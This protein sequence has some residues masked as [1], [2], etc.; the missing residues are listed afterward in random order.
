MQKKEEKTATFR[1]VSISLSLSHS[2][3]LTS[4][5][6][7]IESKEEKKGRRS[8]EEAIIQLGRQC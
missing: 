2:L 7:N 3:L 5:L 8:G 6:G 4:L 1:G